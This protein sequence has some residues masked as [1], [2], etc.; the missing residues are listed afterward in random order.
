MVLLWRTQARFRPLALSYDARVTES[1]VT[2]SG[3][4]T[5]KRVESAR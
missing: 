5:A 1:C 3:L 4:T 2:L